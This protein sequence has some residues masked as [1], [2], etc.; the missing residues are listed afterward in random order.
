MASRTLD[1]HAVGRLLFPD[2]MTLDDAT[3]LAVGGQT[4]RS[5][6]WLADRNLP[7]AEAK[8]QLLSATREWLDNL[9]RNPSITV[10]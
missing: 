7:A 10:A 4:I 2:A 9:A 3:T 6:A 1:L 8:D 5:I